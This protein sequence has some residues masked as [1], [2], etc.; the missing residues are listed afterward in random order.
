[1]ER[2]V[3]D[4][5]HLLIFLLLIF[6][7]TQLVLINNIPLINDEAY[8]LTIG[9]FFSLS[10][11]DHPPLMMWISHFCHYF[12]VTEPYIFRIP[13]VVFGT[14]TSYFLYKIGSIVYTKKVGAVA[15]TL[16]FISPFFF[17]SGG[18]FVVPDASLNFS[19]AGATYLSIKLIF[20]NENKIYLWVL[21]GLFLSLAFLSKYQSYLFGVSLFVAFVIWKRKAIFSKN[22]CFALLLSM[23][24]LVPVLLWNIENNFDSFIFHQKRSSFNLNLLHIFNSFS[25]QIFFLLPTTGFLIAVSLYRY[26]TFRTSQ[27]SFLVFLALP[28][29]FTFNIFI[30]LSD[31]SFAHWAMVGWMLL[32]PMA[33]NNLVS[34]GLFRP[35]LIAIKFL[36]VFVVVFIISTAL[37]HSKTGFLTKGYGE[38]PPEWDN[39]RELLDWKNIAK[40]L[41][42]TL[43][44]EEMSSI[45]TLNWYDSGQLSSAFNYNYFVGVIGPNGNHFKYLD[46]KIKNFT[47]LIGVRLLNDSSN[48]NISEK[49]LAYGYKAYKE[50]KLPLLRGN[51]KYGVISILFI[52]RVN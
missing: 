47:T 44:K 34:L 27:E 46:S 16:Y 35:K 45:A 25:A 29:I 52:H 48:S 42:N 5:S 20:K 22:F 1:M 8:T 2:K 39:T 3:Y 6:F 7:F 11:F 36:C 4:H 13:Y 50:I 40:I 10:Y 43:K 18:F 30:M 51:K 24:G 14:L 31:T 19:I 12:K 26:I 32:I 17:L 21:L 41:E 23:I 37:I 9:R 28:T 33:S 15:A 38:K 49:L